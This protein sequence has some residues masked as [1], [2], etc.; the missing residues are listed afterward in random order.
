MDEIEGR[1]LDNV[2][3]REPYCGLIE[4]CVLTNFEGTGTDGMTAVE[5]GPSSSSSSSCR[6]PKCPFAN[7][8][9]CAYVEC[10]LDPH[11]QD[12]YGVAL[13]LIEEG[14]RVS[15]QDWSVVGKNGGDGGTSLGGNDA[16]RV[17]GWGIPVK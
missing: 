2:A 17:G 15:D 12:K 11:V 10:C 1:L 8:A 9:A 14:E 7:E 6:P 13:G 16:T 4:M 3:K 5:G